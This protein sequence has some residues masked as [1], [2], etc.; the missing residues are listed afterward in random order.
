MARYLGRDMRAQAAECP[1]GRMLQVPTGVL[2]FMK[3]TFDPFPQTVE[4][5]L[6]IGGPGGALVGA[7]GVRMSRPR[8]SR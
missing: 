6:D 8:V 1:A 7:R 3:G 4:P 2:H 5:A